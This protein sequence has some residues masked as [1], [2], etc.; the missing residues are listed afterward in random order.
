MPELPEVQCVV[1]SLED[2]VGKKIE[3]VQIK[4][5]QLRERIDSR[6]G[7]RLSGKRVVAVSRR[8]KYA[9]LHLDDG[10]LLVHLGMTG[11]LLLDFPVQKHECLRIYLSSGDTLS[12]VDSRRFGVVA[13]IQSL[14]DSKYLAGMGVEPLTEQFTAAY[15][16][17]RTRKS[18]RPIKSLLLDQ[19]VVAGLGNI[20]VCEVLYHCGIHPLR[21][22]NLITDSDAERIVVETKRVLHRA[23]SVGGSSIS[24]Y[25]DARNRAGSFQNEFCVYGREMDPNGNPVR[26]QRSAGRGTYWSEVAQRDLITR[27]STKVRMSGAQ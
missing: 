24:D 17:D 21:Q 3:S 9:I 22:A 4:N 26:Y 25:R 16:L 2:I 27:V 11:K 15:L 8:G 18:R 6:L 1:K 23:I 20:Y 19:K 5:S 10:F 13:F 7:D 12:Y 14:K